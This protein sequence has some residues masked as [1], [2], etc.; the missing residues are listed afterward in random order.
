M[1]PA[2]VRGGWR[3]EGRGTCMFKSIRELGNVL[4]FASDGLRYLL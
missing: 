4:T 3:G 2:K 1:S